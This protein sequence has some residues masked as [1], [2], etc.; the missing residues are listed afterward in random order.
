MALNERQMK[1]IQFV[2]INSKLT[3]ADYQKLTKVSRQT[4]T[5]DLFELVKKGI[6]VR[7]GKGRGARY[8]MSRILPHK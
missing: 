2:K 8:L 3:S 5:R 1:A 6:L 4:I 7:E